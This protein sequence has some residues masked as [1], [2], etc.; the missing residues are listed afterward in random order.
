M[1]VL[2]LELFF[3]HVNGLLE[4]RHIHLLRVVH[5][6]HV[7][8]STVHV[9]L[10]SKHGCHVGVYHGI[11]LRLWWGHLLIHKRLSPVPPLNYLVVTNDGWYLTSTICL[12]DL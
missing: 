3:A 7:V 10:G 1:D 9:L 8:P 5:H 4:L 6:V 12:V 2:L 11:E